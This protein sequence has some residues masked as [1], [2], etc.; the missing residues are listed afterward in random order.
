M[1]DAYRDNQIDRFVCNEMSPE[2]RAAFCLQLQADEELQKQVK[3]RGLLAEAV[4][5][6]MEEEAFRAMKAG[7]SKDMRRDCKETHKKSK[8]MSKECKG[9]KESTDGQKV[10][11]KRHLIIMRNCA[12]IAAVLLGL[13][14]FI[15]N[16]HR[17][18]P[19]EL[20]RV[21]YV[22]PAIE[23]SRGG[24]EVASALRDASCCLKQGRTQETIARITPQILESIY[25]EEAE[26]LLLCAYLQAGE[27]A[28]AKETALS[29]CRENG[30]YAA[31]AAAIL[32]QLEEKRWF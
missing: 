14:F 15:G 11:S 25:G 23:P 9:C 21:H 5:Q 17:Y 3:L 19:Q 20:F 8:E 24:N 29:I 12:A 16:S 7:Y 10:R 6:E 26:W 22:E 28:K 32:K 1:T 4:T 31:E 27:R 30:L 13:L 2:E 18:S